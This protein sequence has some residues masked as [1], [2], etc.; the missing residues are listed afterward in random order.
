MEIKFC[1]NSRYSGTK[2]GKLSWGGGAEHVT[3][4]GGAAM[5][6]ADAPRK[7]FKIRTSRLLIR[8]LK[9]QNFNMRKFLPLNML[10]TR[11]KTVIK[12]EYCYVQEIT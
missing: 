10:Y 1:Q 9:T 3:I 4:E 5:V 6:G 12:I 2:Q 8:A 11:I 7:F